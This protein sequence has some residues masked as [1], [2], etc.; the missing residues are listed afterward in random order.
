MTPCTNCNRNR[1]AALY[2]LAL[3]RVTAHLCA[4]C[5]SA[6]SSLG[7]VWVPCDRR[8]TDI[9]PMVERRHRPAWL[10]RLTARDESGRMVA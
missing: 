6:L 1:E 4:E 2:K 5:R 9:T 10:D 8:E 7:M 3:R